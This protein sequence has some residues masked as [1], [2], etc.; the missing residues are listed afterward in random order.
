MYDD[1]INLPT[2][3][4]TYLHMNISSFPYHFKGLKYLVENCQN[5]PKLIEITECRLR[6][7]KTALSN[8]DLQDFTYEW[9]ATTASKGGTIYID[10]KL[11]YKTRNDLKLYK[12]KEIESNFLEIIEPN[13]KKNKIIGCIYIVRTPLFKGGE[14]NFK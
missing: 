10:N 1:K 13:N 8:I 5:K 4:A 11:T 9:T 6:A 7:N 3:L 2:Y 12:E 14:V